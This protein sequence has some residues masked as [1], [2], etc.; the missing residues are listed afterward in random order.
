MTRCD[1]NMFHMCQDI[2]SHAN[3]FFS[4]Q[5]YFITLLTLSMYETIVQHKSNYHAIS[6]KHHCTVHT[7]KSGRIISQTL[8][9]IHIVTSHLR[10][11][12]HILHARTVLILPLKQ[13]SYISSATLL[14]YLNIRIRFQWNFACL[15]ITQPNI[16]WIWDQI[17]ILLQPF[18]MI[19]PKF[20]VRF[21]RTR[22]DGS[23]FKLWT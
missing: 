13:L 23:V 8:D 1:V 14:T 11:T 6:T 12:G 20:W 17:C 16:V 4:L 2:N 21:W 19:C 22:Q 5:T 9:F 7:H 10:T 15:I 3:S 18:G